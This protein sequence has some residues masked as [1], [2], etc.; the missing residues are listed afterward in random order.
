MGSFVYLKDNFGDR[1]GTPRPHRSGFEKGAFVKASS[2]FGNREGWRV[3]PRGLDWLR[4][5]AGEI[6]LKVA[7][8][9]ARK[10]RTKLAAKQFSADR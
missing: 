2:D 8:T 7:E 3:K 1:I 10:N 4:N 6:N 9:K 5:K